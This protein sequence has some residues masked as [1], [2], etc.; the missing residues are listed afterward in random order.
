M[1]TILAVLALI[2]LM[3]MCD[4]NPT[5]PQSSM[6]GRYE[7]VGHD[8]LGRLVFTGTISLKSLEQNHLKGECTI[9]REKD[10]PEGLLDQ[11]GDCEASLD[12]KKV[13]LD[14]APSL[15]DAGLLLEGEL[16]AVRISGV[17]RLDGFATSK[18]LGKF[19]AA[20]KE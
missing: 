16:N 20:K 19:E 15:D 13:D 6:L 7:L 14:L 17:W 5:N 3:G 12:G 10:A 8:S 11:Q 1:K 9:T 2:F 18:P 4:R